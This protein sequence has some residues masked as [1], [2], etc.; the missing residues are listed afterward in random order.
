MIDRNQE[1]VFPFSGD[2]KLKTVML[3]PDGLYFTSKTNLATPA[4]FRE[5][6]EKGGLDK[7]TT[8]KIMVNWDKV[9]RVKW[10]HGE[11]KITLS[12]KG[13]T[14]AATTID[15]S[16]NTDAIQI[17]LT[18]VEAQGYRR[19]E[20]TISGMK[21]TYPYLG[22]LALTVFVTLLIL[23]LSV[24]GGPVRTNII[25]HLI[26]Q[27]G[28]FLGPV[29]TIGVGLLV[30]AFITYLM[31]KAYKNPPVVTTLEPLMA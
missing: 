24:N 14:Q 18:Y 27:L 25:G 11:N 17:V 8:T 6:F 5:S 21:A 22:G 16:D 7:L 20:E 10:E 30:C 4:A 3:S 19:A 28:M 2:E 31:I 26:I 15:L 12:Y 9:K 13:L 1:I 23:Y 29:G